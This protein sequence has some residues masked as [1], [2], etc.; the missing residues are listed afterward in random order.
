MKAP[1]DRLET[2]LG[3][4]FAQPRLLAQALRHSSTTRGPQERTLSNQRME[5]LGDR[6]LGMV[7]AQFLYERF[8]GEEEGDLAR[9]H[10]ALVR[11]EALARVAEGIGLAQHLVMSKSEEEAGGRANPGLLADAMEAVIAALYLDGGQ[12]VADAFIRRYWMALMEEDTLP[13][14]DAKTTLQEWAQGRGL[15]LPHYRETGRQGPAHAPTFIIEVAVG[16][17]APIEASGSSKRAAEQEAARAML[18]RLEK[19]SNNG[20]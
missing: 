4:D 9:R 13:P 2:L 6:V 7:V 14:Q 20:R 19:E 17:A 11:R 1:G 8:A 3:H 15:D 12:K 5:F 18:D 10:A 16:D